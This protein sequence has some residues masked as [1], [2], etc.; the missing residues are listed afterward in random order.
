MKTYRM[1]LIGTQFLLASA[2]LWLHLR[3]H[4][5]LKS[6]TLTGTAKLQI[7]ELVAFIFCVVDVLL[8]TGLFLKQETAVYGYLL[9]GMLVIFGAVM[10]THLSI[11]FKITKNLPFSVW[12]WQTTIPDIM[13]AGA[14]FM[15]GRT[16]YYSWVR[17]RAD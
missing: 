10:M 13:L 15:V 17:Q 14:D 16:I 1:P 8:I 3:I 7:G 12:I 6:E 2:A 11:A 4:P 5:F 9:N